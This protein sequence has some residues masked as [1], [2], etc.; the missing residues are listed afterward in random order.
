MKHPLTPIART[1]R[2][3][4]TKYE[5]LL[6][7]HVRDRQLGGFKFR[8]QMPLGSY[9]V[10]YVC[11][12]T[13]VVVELDGSGHATKKG[14]AADAVRDAALAE[15]D[16]LVL[17]FWNSEV[18]KDLP[19]VLETIYQACK[20]RSIPENSHQQIDQVAS[21]LAGEGQRERA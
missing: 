1:L 19:V 5:R 11:F 8:R 20:A 6:W 21:P 3:R 4:S 2:K 15:A 12:E 14:R 16:F 10:D 7:K 9:V 13:K 17:R 18:T